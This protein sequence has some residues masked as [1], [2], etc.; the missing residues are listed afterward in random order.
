MAVVISLLIL[1]VV[2]QVLTLIQIKKSGTDVSTETAKVVP[3]ITVDTSQISSALP[4]ATGDAEEEAG[5]RDQPPN[6]PSN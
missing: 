3:E 2:L 4:D 6:A 5:E 1:V